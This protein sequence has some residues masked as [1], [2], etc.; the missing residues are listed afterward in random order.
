[1]F[2]MRGGQQN[3]G[4]SSAQPQHQVPAQELGAQVPY[5]QVLRS[6]AHLH[7]CS[8]CRDAGRPCDAHPKRLCPWG[9]RT[10][11]TEGQLLKRDPVWASHNSRF[12]IDNNLPEADSK[13]QADRL[14]ES[15]VRK[16]ADGQLKY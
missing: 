8:I 7:P 11:D 12:M 4:A 2:T 5:T 15:A 16:L 3:Q 13:E 10:L 1:M 9:Y 14:L 6:L